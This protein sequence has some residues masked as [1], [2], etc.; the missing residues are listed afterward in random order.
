MKNIQKNVELKP[1]SWWKVGGSADYFYLPQTLEELEK[2]CR[3]AQ[4]Q[5][6]PISVLSGGTNVL[7]SDQG[8]EGLVIGLKNLRNIHV[9]INEFEILIQALA[10]APKHELFKIFSRYRI[11]P[12]LFLCGLPGDVGGG[13]V[14]N[15]GVSGNIS[16][17]E[18]SQIVHE[19]EVFSLDSLKLKKF[20]K[21]DLKWSYRSCQGW[22]KG[23]IYQASFKWSLD[24]LKDFTHKLREVNKKRTSSQP[25][26]QPSCGSVFKN[27]LDYRSGQLI[28]RAGL[29]GF[30]IGGAEVSQ[31]H[32]NFIVNKGD[33]TASDIHQ[34][35]CYVQNK[36]KNDFGVFLEP[37]IHYLGRWSS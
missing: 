6:I 5:S 17:Y 25:L 33:A 7:I 27:P 4:D 14:M 3:W 20:S 18:F 10:G 13:V 1:Y 36:V 21:Q 32:S 9:K 37:E 30:S 12:A 8:V 23:I 35:I 11:A 24:P 19:V 26:N 22:G 29:K 34:V 15:A 2:A 31:R 16:P 28:E